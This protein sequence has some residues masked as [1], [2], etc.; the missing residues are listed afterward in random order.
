MGAVGHVRAGSSPHLPDEGLSVPEDSVQWAGH[1]S[2]ADSGVS[3]LDAPEREPLSHGW[4][5]AP[6]VVIM[7]FVA[8]FAAGAL[9]MAIELMV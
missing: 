9:G 8:I 6:I 3:G 5:A 1:T 2:P 7:V 4:G